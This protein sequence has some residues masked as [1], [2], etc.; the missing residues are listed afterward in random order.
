[1]L[2]SG[3]FNRSFP[4]P[5]F[6]LLPFPPSSPKPVGLAYA[7]AMPLRK[8]VLWLQ[9]PLRKSSVASEATSSARQ[10]WKQTRRDLVYAGT[11]AAH[12]QLQRIGFEQV[13]FPTLITST[14]WNFI[15][16]WS[17]AETVSTAKPAN[18]KAMRAFPFPILA[19]AT[20]REL[21]SPLKCEIRSL[22]P[23]R[24]TAN[25]KAS[26]YCMRCV[27]VIVVWLHLIFHRHALERPDIRDIRIQWRVACSVCRRFLSKW[28]Y[29]SRSFAS[30]RSA[31]HAGT[32]LESK[33]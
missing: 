17:F 24:G 23:A 33:L 21:P 28:S 10:F 6:A 14:I 9:K 29:K 11:E 8:R 4:L 16:G 30:F 19:K 22:I 20:S 13:S 2:M 3:H 5:P 12:L 18:I 26:T 1:M 27:F 15:M 32:I 31:A 7:A 25:W